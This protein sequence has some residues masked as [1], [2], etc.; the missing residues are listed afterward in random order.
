MELYLNLKNEGNTLFSKAEYR[1]AHFKFCEAIKLVQTDSKLLSVLYSN[2]S[3]CSFNLNEYSKAINEADECI[4]NNPDWYKGYFRKA[5]AYLKLNDIENFNICIKNC[6]D[7]TKTDLERKEIEKFIESTKI[8]KK[9]KKLFGN[10]YEDKNTENEYME[11][12]QNQYDWLMSQYIK[13]SESDAFRTLGEYHEVSEDELS[14]KS[15]QSW[16]KYGEKYG[17]GDSPELLEILKEYV[18]ENNPELKNNLLIKIN[19]YIN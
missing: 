13:P 9:S 16:I 15:A 1:Q 5:N 8:V 17:C 10:I 2:L 4:M 6:L 14:D 19:K 18:N 11:S 3:S 7:L 12:V